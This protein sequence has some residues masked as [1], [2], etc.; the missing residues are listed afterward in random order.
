[1]TRASKRF[2]HGSTALTRPPRLVTPT[3]NLK[4]L[5]STEIFDLTYWLIG[6]HGFS[7]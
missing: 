1:M 5:D 4:Y 7:I 3:R 2:G 6:R